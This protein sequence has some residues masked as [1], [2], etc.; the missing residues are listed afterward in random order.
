VQSGGR[1]G[2][3]GLIDTRAKDQPPQT[4]EAPLAN[5][6]RRLRQTIK[7][8][9]RASRIYLETLPLKLITSLASLFAYRSLIVIGQLA[10]ILPRR[11]AF[12]WNWHLTD[13]VSAKALQKWTIEPQDISAILFRS[14]E[15]WYPPDYGW[16][17]LCRQLTVVVVKGDHG[18]LLRPPNLEGLC[19]EFWKLVETASSSVNSEIKSSGPSVVSNELAF[20][21]G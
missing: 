12:G 4:P 7:Q 6:M 21:S 11:I 14:D 17:A 8:P 9:L 16:R 18:S 19:A 10:K 2:F 5:S 15:R 20:E 1:I 3:L 13:Q